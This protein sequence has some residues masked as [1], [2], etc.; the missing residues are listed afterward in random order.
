ML[1]NKPFDQTNPAAGYVNGNP[2]TNTAGSIPC[3]E[4]LEYPQR[5]IV[6]AIAA[7]GLTPTNADLTQLLQAIRIL[8]LKNV[9]GSGQ[10]PIIVA[11]PIIYVRTDGN[12]SNDGSANDAAHALATIDA[13]LAKVG[14]YSLVGT[15]LKIKLGIPGTYAY[16][17][18]TVKAAGGTIIIE[19]DLTNQ[20]NY[21]VS[22]SGFGSGAGC[23]DFVGVSTQLNGLNLVNTGGTNH[24]L[25]AEA[26]ASVFCQ[27]VTLTQSGTETGFAH[28]F[29][30]SAGT[31]TFP[32]GNG[33]KFVG[34]KGAMLW[35]SGGTI[36]H[37][38]L[39]VVG[40]PNF[41]IATVISNFLG[42]VAILTGRVLGLHR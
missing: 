11:N 28:V 24:T 19:G 22:G 13:A 34:S 32:Q 33:C 37:H 5:E 41:A 3:A 2:A 17:S 7:A 6:A 36:N 8:A 25:V 1:Y 10:V 9:T 31:V 29:A 39:A 40:T 20:D 14:R 35:A 27:N 26:G 18:T 42:L 21:L 38:N 30:K 4:G 12:D 15:S 23:F 16:P